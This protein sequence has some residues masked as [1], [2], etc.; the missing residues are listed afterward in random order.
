[1]N[2]T[3]RESQLALL[4]AEMTVETHD[5]AWSLCGERAGLDDLRDRAKALLT[6][7]SMKDYPQNQAL[8]GLFLRSLA[9]EDQPWRETEDDLMAVF[10]TW[11]AT[12]PGLENGGGAEDL[13]FRDDLTTEQ[14]E[15]L[16]HFM[17]RWEAMEERRSDD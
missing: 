5:W 12:Q 9:T 11:T 6:P 15:W 2:M 8:F 4:L 14:R 17:R 7:L 16:S 10:A 3:H 13:L 1:M